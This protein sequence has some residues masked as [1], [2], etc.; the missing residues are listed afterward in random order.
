M[1]LHRATLKIFQTIAV[2]LAFVTI[3]TSA[4]TVSAQDVP[5]ECDP[6]VLVPGDP[7]KSFTNNAASFHGLRDSLQVPV[8][9]VHEQMLPEPMHTGAWR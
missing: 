8:I 3:A 2:K 1:R 9:M 6:R 4:A 7:Y 5:Y